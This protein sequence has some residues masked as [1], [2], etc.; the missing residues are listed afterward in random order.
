MTYAARTQVPVAETQAEIQALLRKRK[1]DRYAFMEATDQGIVSFEFGGRR[2]V[3]HLPLPALPD[4]WK[5]ETGRARDLASAEAVWE[6]ALRSRWRALFL[7][8]KAKFEAVDTGVVTLEDEFLAH[9]VM[10]GGET[11]GSYV[12]RELPKLLRG[13]QVPLLPPPKETYS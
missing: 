7:V 11:V 1:A 3:F 9:A 12:N 2:Y 4:Y 10:P 6:Q 8:I 13:E 5:T